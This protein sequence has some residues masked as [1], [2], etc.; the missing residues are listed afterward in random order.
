MDQAKYEK[1]LRDRQRE[2][3]SRLNRIDD[4]LGHEKSAD[5]EDRAI[6]RENDEV[7]EE[8]GQAGEVELKAIA[9]ALHRVSQ[10]TFGECVNCG[11]PISQERLDVIP[12][13]PFCK[14]CAAEL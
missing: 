7:L 11:Q 12:Y 8:L 1:I 9:A 5:S 4:D 14:A 2:I 10:G 3:N 6:E 13:T